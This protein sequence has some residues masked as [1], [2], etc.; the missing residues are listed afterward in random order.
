MKE[1][2]IMAPGPHQKRSK[3]LPT[4]QGP[5]LARTMVTRQPCAAGIQI[6]IEIKEFNVM[7][8]QMGN[9]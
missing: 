3:D 9:E 2:I 8:K 5:A 4:T 1:V 6:S 7:A